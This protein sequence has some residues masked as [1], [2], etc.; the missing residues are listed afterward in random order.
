MHFVDTIK[1]YNRRQEFAVR[2]ELGFKCYLAEFYVSKAYVDLQFPI[3]H[4]TP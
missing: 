1:V 4:K 2:Q 3:F